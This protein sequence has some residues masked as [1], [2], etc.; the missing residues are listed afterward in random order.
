MISDSAFPSTV[1][2]AAPAT[3]ILNPKIKTGSRMILRNV[4]DKF[5]AID[6]FTEPSARRIFTKALENSMIVEP[7]PMIFRY[8]M[9]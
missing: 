1:A 4:P 6:S 3:P 2:T 5:A 9:A 8:V 7:E